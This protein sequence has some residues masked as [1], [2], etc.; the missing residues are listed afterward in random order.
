MFYVSTFGGSAS[1]WFAMAMSLHP[2]IVCFHGSRS[3][4][5]APPGELA[6]LT[7]EEYARG[8]HHMFAACRRT[9]LFG[10]IHGFEGL[11]A[12]AAFEAE[13]GAFV[14]LVRHPVRRIHSLFH[15]YAA[16]VENYA[17][18]GDD[19]YSP[20]RG[21]RWQDV[22]PTVT[23]DGIG[24]HPIAERFHQLC[25]GTVSGDVAC[26]AALPFED[27]LVQER[28]TTDP[29]YFARAFRRLVAPFHRAQALAYAVEPDPDYL[30][31]VFAAGRDNV[32]VGLHDPTEDI[33]AAWPPLFRTIF[34]LC[35]KANG[36]AGAFEAYHR[37][38]Y[39]LPAELYNVDYARTARGLWAGVLG[40]IEAQRL[41]DSAYAPTP[42]EED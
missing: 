31:A 28:L 36:G 24:L 17:W 15:T 25:H 27:V 37:I 1:A 22:E 18:T 42:P 40:R 26:I 30:A 19:P 3:L 5:P 6:D 10:A 14:A 29:E 4:P 38:G 33:F 21:A 20:L 9:T 39:R 41:D 13:K 16:T 32:R 35:L 7:P 34:V 8:L 23:R 2:R 12:K 11:S